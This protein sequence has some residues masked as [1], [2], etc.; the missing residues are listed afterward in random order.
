MAPP[1]YRSPLIQLFSVMAES[2]LMGR[3]L[4]QIAI[5]CLYAHVF[6]FARRVYHAYIADTLDLRVCH[7][8]RLYPSLHH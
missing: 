2:L 7:L 8:S 5:A 4:S 6:G 1:E 3:S